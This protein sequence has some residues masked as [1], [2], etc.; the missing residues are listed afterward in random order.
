MILS[1]P[2]ISGNGR[3]KRE[4]RFFRPDR[5]GNIEFSS[6]TEVNS[7]GFPQE[8][9]SEMLEPDDGKLSRPVLRREGGSDAS[10]LSD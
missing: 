3:I 4:A 2:V 6:P 1:M 10:D 7:R 5:P 8:S 9:P